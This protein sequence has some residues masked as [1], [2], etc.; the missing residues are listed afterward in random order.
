MPAA[1]LFA[2]GETLKMIAP[3]AQIESRMFVIREHCERVEPKAPGTRRRP[4]CGDKVMLDE[5]LAALYEVETKVLNRVVKRNIERFPDDFMFQLSADEFASLRFQYGTSNLRSQIVTSNE[6]PSGRGGRRYAPYAFTEQGVSMLSS[7]L[8]SERAIQVNIEIMRAF[9]GDVMKRL[10]NQQIRLH[11]Y[12]TTYTL[13]TS[14]RSDS[15]APAKT[16]WPDSPKKPKG[17]QGTRFGK[18]SSA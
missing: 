6:N 13:N 18:S 15:P 8:R 14:S 5:D 2:K 1:P 10:R 12:L 9:G 7:V 3:V 16:I 4:P 11:H 17:W